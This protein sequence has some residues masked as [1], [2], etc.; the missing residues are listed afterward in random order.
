MW[1][2]E[3]LCNFRGTPLRFIKDGQAKT[4]D[5]EI[6]GL[7][8]RSFYERYFQ[9]LH[10]EKIQNILEI[11][12]FEGASA[13]MFSQM[14]PSSK[15]VGI[16]IRPKNDAVLRHLERFKLRDR[17]KLYY[18]IS[19]DDSTS[20]N[21]IIKKEFGHTPLDFIVDDASHQYPLTR[22][23]FEITFPHLREKGVYAIEDWGWAHWRGFPQPKHWAAQPAL[24]NLIFELTMMSATRENLVDEL[25]ISSGVTMISKGHAKDEEIAINDLFETA[26]RTWRHL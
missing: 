23:T 21:E 17:V 24:S 26:G 16:D 4:T 3:E 5:T 7:K 1:T 2:S 11:G 20:I 15:I 18:E 10:S 6:V 19:Q 25:T 9:A 12:I 22:R 13:M 8:G 14:F